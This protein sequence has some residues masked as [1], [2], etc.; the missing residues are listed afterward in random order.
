[1]LTESQAEKYKAKHGNVIWNVHKTIDI[2]PDLLEE[3]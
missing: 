2:S 3:K 1:M